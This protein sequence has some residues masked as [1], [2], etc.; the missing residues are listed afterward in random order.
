MNFNPQNEAIMEEKF[1]DLLDE[2]LGARDEFIKET[3]K[4]T[5]SINELEF[6][7]GQ[8]QNAKDNMDDFLKRFSVK[9]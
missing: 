8:L 2:F 6:L 5:P 3:D 1:S 7:M 9:P 4:Q